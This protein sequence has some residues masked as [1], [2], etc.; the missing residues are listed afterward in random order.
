VATLRKQFGIR[1]RQ[2][3]AQ[4]RMTQERFAE[5]LNLSVDFLSLVERGINAPSFESLERIARRLRIPVAD[6]FKFDNETHA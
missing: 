1:L 5:T 3:R 4:R 2:I 6:L